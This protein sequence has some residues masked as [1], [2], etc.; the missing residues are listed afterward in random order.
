MANRPPTWRTRGESAGDLADV[1]PSRVLRPVTLD[2]WPWSSAPR[3]D[4]GTY[5]CSGEVPGQRWGC[6]LL[7]SGIGIPDDGGGG[8]SVANVSLAPGPGPFL[9]LVLVG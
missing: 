6:H 8:S 5:C 4:R 9:G 3:N 1:S 7:R 2:A